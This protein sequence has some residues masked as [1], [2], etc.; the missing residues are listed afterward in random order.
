MLSGHLDQ[1]TR[2]TQNS[3]TNKLLPQKSNSLF[4]QLEFKHLFTEAPQSIRTVPFV[5]WVAWVSTY[6]LFG[7]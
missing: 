5:I 4:L 2:L 7:F 3:Q 1:G 6:L